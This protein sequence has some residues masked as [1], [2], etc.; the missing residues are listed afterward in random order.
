MA[1]S[2]WDARRTYAD[3]TLPPVAPIT[4]MFPLLCRWSSTMGPDIWL[5]F[6]GIL[7][8]STDYD[9]PPGGVPADSLA[10]KEGVASMVTKAV[11]SYPEGGNFSAPANAASNSSKGRAGRVAAWK[12]NVEVRETEGAVLNRKGA[13]TLS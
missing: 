7:H 4:D 13:Y 8:P 6:D 10:T 2:R 3:Y 9:F 11:R 5:A 1:L 12:V